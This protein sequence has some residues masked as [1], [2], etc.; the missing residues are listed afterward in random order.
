[1][2]ACNITN[3]APRQSTKGWP[4]E[5]RRWFEARWSPPHHDTGRE[6]AIIHAVRRALDD[7]QH[8]EHLIVD[9]YGKHKH[10]KG[11]RS[12]AARPR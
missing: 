6:R 8:L 10:A 5:W 3:P 2:T 1:M 4:S 9:S 12:L 11:K 7:L